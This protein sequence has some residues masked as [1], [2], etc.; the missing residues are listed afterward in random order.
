MMTTYHCIT[1]GDMDAESAANGL[2]VRHLLF[3]SRFW[4]EF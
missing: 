3:S 4:R 2:L 1:A